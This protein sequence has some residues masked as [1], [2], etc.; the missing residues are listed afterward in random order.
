VAWTRPQHKAEV[1]NAAANRLLSETGTF[2]EVEVAQDIVNNFRSSHS[3]PLNTFQVGLR[4]LA[5]HGAVIAQRLKR[6]P[7]ILAKLELRQDTM[8]LSQ[9][10][11]I[12]GCRAILQSVTSVRAVREAYR[13]SEM[14]HHFQNEKDYIADPRESGYRGMHLVYR[15]FSDKN[16][17]WNGLKIE[18]QLRSQIQHAW[19]TAVE[20]IGTFLGKA[21]KSSQGDKEW[22]E[23]LKL[24]SSA[25]A[26]IERSP[27]VPGT[28]TNQKALRRAI[29]ETAGRLRVYQTLAG[30]R[31]ALDMRD[32]PTHAKADYFLM[33]LD[34]R[35]NRLRVRGFRRQE[36][37]RAQQEYLEAERELAADGAAVLVSVSSM[38]QLKRAYPNFYQDTDLFVSLVRRVSRP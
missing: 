26:L 18:I 37:E 5:P 38:D 34:Y 28:P 6:L 33:M 19:A 31:S 10:Q 11:D 24:V 35:Q 27:L 23:W 13:R 15:Y 32:A 3:Y 1:Y 8:K 4:R 21:L 22:L 29:R 12:G 25:F 9:M 36:M 20:S 16:K 17:T 2:D 14:K 7:S 30:V